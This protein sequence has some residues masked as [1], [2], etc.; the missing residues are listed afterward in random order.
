MYIFRAIFWM[1]RKRALSNV[2]LII[3]VLGYTA[4]VQAQVNSSQQNGSKT[5][6][7]PRYLIFSYLIFVM[8][9]HHFL[10]H[11]MFLLFDVAFGSETRFDVTC[12][13]IYSF[14]HL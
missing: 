4:T 14:N 11:F 8:S 2:L 1:S 9:F 13:R 6:E 3:V 5:G 12:S 10:N 7:W